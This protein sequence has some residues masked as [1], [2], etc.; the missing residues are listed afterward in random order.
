MTNQNNAAQAAPQQT[1]LTREQIGELYKDWVCVFGVSTGSA[2]L[3]IREIEAAVLSQLRAPV[4]DDLVASLHSMASVAPTSECEILLAAASALASAPVTHYECGRS[5]GDGTYAAVPVRAPVAGEAPPTDWQN[6]LRIAEL[7]EADEALAVFCNDGTLDN[8]V[9]LVQAI[10]DAAPQ[11]S[12]VDGLPAWWERFMNELT[13]RSED[14]V[15]NDLAGILEICALDAIASAAPQASEAVQGTEH[16]AQGLGDV[17]LPRLPPITHKWAALI[18]DSMARALENWARAYTR[19]AILADRQQRAGN[20]DEYEKMRDVLQWIVD[21]AASGGVAKL[22]PQQEKRARA[23]LSA[24]PVEEPAT[25]APSPAASQR[26][27]MIPASRESG[28]SH[29]DGGAVY[30]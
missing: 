18:S 30:E 25:S 19:T 14:E 27:A 16:M 8:A 17:V 3:C 21:D 22:R 11:A 7:P 24:Q 26:Q 4:A 1:V 2:E 13:L 23:A 20:A 6:A 10:L 29:T 9:G 12:A 15:R 28:N 5:N